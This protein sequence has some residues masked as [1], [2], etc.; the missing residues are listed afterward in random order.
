[1]ADKIE[2]STLLDHLGPTVNILFFVIESG[3]KDVQ[4]CHYQR[5]IAPIT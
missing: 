2:V 4:E 3:N 5:K 1:V